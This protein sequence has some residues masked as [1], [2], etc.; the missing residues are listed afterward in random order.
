MGAVGIKP[1]LSCFDYVHDLD[2]TM[3]V[4]YMVMRTAEQ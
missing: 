3:D 4:L 1:L 2:L